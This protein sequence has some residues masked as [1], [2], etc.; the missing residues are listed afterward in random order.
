MIIYLNTKN[1]IIPKSK[2]SGS[3]ILKK[4]TNRCLEE[5]L[6]SQLNYT[7]RM[8]LLTFLL[9]LIFYFSQ[10]DANEWFLA[11]TGVD[12]KKSYIK[13]LEKK[14]SDTFACW[15]KMISRVKK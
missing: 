15:F 6:K 5:T 7:M 13:N 14:N 1:L 8:L 3:K 11:N 9:F 10:Q 4:F 12:G 2:I